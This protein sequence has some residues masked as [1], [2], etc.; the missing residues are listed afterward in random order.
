M[1][2]QCQFIY[3]SSKK[4]PWFESEDTMGKTGLWRTSETGGQALGHRPS[5]SWD[6]ASAMP[7]LGV[8]TSSSGKRGSPDGPCLCKRVNGLVHVGKWGYRLGC[9]IDEAGSQGASWCFL[10]SQC[11]WY[12][13][14]SCSRDQVCS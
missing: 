6:L 14:P 13:F 9:A 10:L 7:L 8:W 2:Y 12:N 11:L 5:L 1:V 3:I 4:M